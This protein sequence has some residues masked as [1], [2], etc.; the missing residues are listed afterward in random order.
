MRINMTKTNLV[1]AMLAAGALAAAG[2]DDGQVQ[3][4]AA[5]ASGVCE[6]T[7]GGGNGGAGGSA[8][9]AGSGVRDARGG[10]R[11][12]PADPYIAPAHSGNLIHLKNNCKFALWINGVGGGG[13]LTPDDLKLNAGDMHDY[14]RGDWPFAYVTAYL[15]GPKQNMI[16][17][18]EVTFFPS[19]LVS[20]RLGYIDGI[21]LPMELRAVGSGTDCKTVGCYATQDQVVAECP[22]GMVSGKRCLSAGRYCASAANAAKPVCHA[23]D[24]QIARCAQ[25]PAKAA[26]CAEA[27]GAT[28][29]QVYSCEQ[30]FG[31]HPA[32]CAALN[33]GMLDDAASSTIGSFYRTGPYNAYAAWL[34]DI[35]PGLNAFPYDDVQTSED[36]FHACSG[37][38]QLNITFCPAG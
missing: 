33:R 10:D 31:D 36:A 7:G 23:L 9:D 22:E 12:V 21:G 16:D 11:F 28:T 4:A 26:G 34:H 24:A 20:Y 27:G 29:A 18:A 32:L 8:T 15:D 25:S 2:C 6:G 1:L 14:T 35:C 30:V 37:S 5:R 19:G 3:T 17:R 38:T 13:I